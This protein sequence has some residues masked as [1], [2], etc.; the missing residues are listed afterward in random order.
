ME[1]YVRKTILILFLS[2]PMLLCAQ[3]FFKGGLGNGGDSEAF[4]ISVELG[5]LLHNKDGH[6]NRMFTFGISSIF[7]ADNIPSDILDYS[8]P[9]SSY[10]KLGKRQD[11]NETAFFG[12]YGMEVFKEKGFYAFLLSGF[13]F[14]FD[15]DLVKSTATGWYYEQSV[16]SRLYGIIGG[17]LT[18]CPNESKFNYSLDIDNRRGISGSIGIYFY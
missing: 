15:I 11:G 8:C 12:R 17:G 14:S 5:G 9:H 3:L 13:S 7:N 16:S 10:D 18:Y 6:R 4:S 1:K 2:F